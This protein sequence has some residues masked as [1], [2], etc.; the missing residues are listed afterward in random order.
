MNR[1]SQKAWGTA[2]LSAVAMALALGSSVGWAGLANCVEPTEVQVAVE[3]TNQD[4]P[5]G[6]EAATTGHANDD[7]K[8]TANTGAAAPAKAFSWKKLLPGSPW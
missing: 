8:A 2:S 3:T 7:G 5:A 4:L 1:R 6:G